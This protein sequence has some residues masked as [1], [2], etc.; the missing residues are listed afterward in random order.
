MKRK[1]FLIII[2]M[3]GLIYMVVPG[4][5][6]VSDFPPLPD[7]SKSDEPGDTYQIPNIAAYFS[8]SDRSEITNFYRREL[9]KKYFWGFLIP[10]ISLNYPPKAAQTYVRDQLYVT[11]LE[12][13]VYP[14]KG[15]IFVAGYEPYIDNEL[16]KRN[17]TFIGDHIHI[18]GNY[19]VSK[20]TLRYYPADLF[21]ALIVYL[22]IWLAGVSLYLL[23]K[24]VLK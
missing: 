11:F 20:T 17:H 21:N 8:Q 2:F 13:Y 3:T 1:V 9:S 23:S 14:L 4:P 16:L 22:G 19:Y 24:R 6:K 7:S 15:S 18:K 12:E 5:S 10:S